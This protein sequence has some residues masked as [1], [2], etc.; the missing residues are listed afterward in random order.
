MHAVE[1]VVADG[2]DRRL[3]REPQDDQPG[4]EVKSVLALRIGRV[5]GQP[6]VTHIKKDEARVDRPVEGP[7]HRSTAPSAP[8]RLSAITAMA[9]TSTC[10]AVHHTQIA[11]RTTISMKTSV[12]T[13]TRPAI[14]QAMWGQDGRRVQSIALTANH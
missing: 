14:D 12:R 8:G 5:A 3:E 7:A 11:P 9:T 13:E 6:G 10:A 2:V 4:A 1:V